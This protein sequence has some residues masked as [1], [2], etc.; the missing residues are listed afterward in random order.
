VNLTG[1]ERF[2]FKLNIH[3]I[4]GVVEFELLRSIAKD[5][6]LC[7]FARAVGAID[8]K[9]LNSGLIVENRVKQSLESGRHVQNVYR[10]FFR[11]F[12]AFFVG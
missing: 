8:R 7:D 12:G 1:V 10:P 6:L 9:T 2:E 3:A 5:R 11:L 4:R